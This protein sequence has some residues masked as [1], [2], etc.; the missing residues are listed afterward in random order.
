M[1]IAISVR[2]DLLESDLD[3]SFG[4]AP[5]FLLFDNET[6]AFTVY[7]NTTNVNAAQG[8]GI[9][10]AEAV[11]RLGATAVITDQA[12]PK[13]FKALNTGGVRIFLASALRNSVEAI[14]AMEKGE[15]V[16]IS[17]ETRQGH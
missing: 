8:A 5:K 2:G 17:S 9:Q 1:K 4:R 15:L 7:D 12:G 3:P 13:A 10:A 16:E 14:A 6:H 11:I